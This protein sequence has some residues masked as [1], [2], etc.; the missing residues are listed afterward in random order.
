MVCTAIHSRWGGDEAFAWATPGLQADPEVVRK[1]ISRDAQA[2]LQISDE[3]LKCNRDLVLLALR[4]DVSMEVAAQVFAQPS[5][6]WKSDRELVMAAV[7]SCGLALRLTDPTFC[8]DKEVVLTAIDTGPAENES[9]GDQIL[10]LCVF[11]MAS[12]GLQNDSVVVSKA[13]H[14]ILNA[15]V[16]NREKYHGEWRRKLK[17]GLTCGMTIV[18]QT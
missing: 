11:T 7:S 13:L 2:W 12:D 6:S 8:S 16:L 4:R 18:G 14:F 17:N 1:A 15:L 3:R 10:E 5:G 9:E